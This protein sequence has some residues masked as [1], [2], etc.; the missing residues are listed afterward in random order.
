METPH[1]STTRV[2]LS[3]G[4]AGRLRPIDPTDAD[5][6][7]RFHAHLSRSTIR[8]RFFGLH[9][10]LTENEVGR[11]TTV[12]GV[13]RVA[14]VVEVGT[15]IVAVGRYDRMENPAVAEVAFVVADALQHH[16][17]GSLLLARLT[18]R[19]RETGITTL[20][21]Q[22]LTGNGAMLGVFREAGCPM[23]LTEAFGVIDVT[24]DITKQV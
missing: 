8:L 6:L 4:T 18:E 2:E 24:L 13:D 15:E 17:L 21:A 20:Y 16:G 9:P 12:D 23:E 22:V 7:R 5:A 14:F 11:F 10:E 3:D 19:A 1:P